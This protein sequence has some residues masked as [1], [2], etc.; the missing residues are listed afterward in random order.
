MNI[1]NISKLS[2]EVFSLKSEEQQMILK[3]FTI[4]PPTNLT[5][6]SKYTSMSEKPLN[7]WKLNRILNGESQILGLVPT[8]FLFIQTENKNRWGKSEKTYFLTIK[9]ILASLSTGIKSDKNFILEK[10]FSFLLQ[11]TKDK[12]LVKLGKIFIKNQIHF[13]LAWHEL[14]GFQLKKLPASYAYYR[15]FANKD[16]QDHI[17]TIPIL[18]SNKGSIK[19]LIDI[20][21]ELL[22]TKQKLLELKK[23]K[24]FTNVK[25]SY[26]YPGSRNS[27]YKTEEYNIDKNPVDLI[28]NWFDNIKNFQITQHNKNFETIEKDIFK[29]EGDENTT[30]KIIDDIKNRLS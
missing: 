7:R 23:S 10:Y 5:T 17:S 18:E 12:E 3:Y 19:K 25:I 21:V 14:K 16:W 15:K 11:H 6:I 1:E 22:H 28:I 13:F 26:F 2:K 20:L 29:K 4:N 8:E 9:G 27:K 30:E 24:S